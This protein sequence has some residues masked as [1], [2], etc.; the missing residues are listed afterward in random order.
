MM[1]K[2]SFVILLTALLLIVPLAASAQQSVAVP[3]VL[4]MQKSQAEQ[5]LRQ[6]GFNPVVQPKATM[7]PGQNGIVIQQFPQAGQ[8]GTRGMTVTLV[9][10]EVPA[11]TVRVPNVMGMTPDQAK[12]EIE[13]AGLRWREN[14]QKAPTADPNKAGKVASQNPADS[15]SIQKGGEV[16]ISV[17]QAQAP[18]QPQAQKQA[19]SLIGMT[20]DQARQVGQN[21]GFIV[22]SSIN[23]TVPNSDPAK[24][25]R[26]GKQEI[27]PQ[28]VILVSLYGNPP[29]G[30]LKNAAMPN[31]VGMTYDQARQT[32]ER[33]GFNWNNVQA[34]RKPVDD[35]KLSAGVIRAQDP[36]PGTTIPT[37]SRLTLWGDIYQERPK[38][39][40]PDVRNLPVEEAKKKI[41]AAGFYWGTR[42]KETPWP[43]Y[44]GKVAEQTPTPG[45]SLSKGESVSL[46]VFQYT[47]SA[48]EVR[49]I[50][51]EQAQTYLIGIKGGTLPYD[52]RLQYDVPKNMAGQKAVEIV[53]LADSPSSPGWK[54]YRLIPKITTKVTMYVTD[55][56]GRKHEYALNVL[57]KK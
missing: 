19:P 31:V 48:L 46:V 6:A 42:G 33:T 57:A 28:N 37:N 45:T 39:A 18:A 5:V 12:R 27:K 2:R 36:K 8:R 29:Q 49:L 23:E 51:M 15:V 47:E 22:V 14:P 53:G 10:F 3:H 50:R 9:A 52:V 4:G 30:Q 54:L 55:A 44:N 7:Y 24:A 13:K 38:I 20:V 26:V 43:Q 21:A 17:Y 25:N 40:V 16:Y 56:K 1:Q 11:S 35:Q 32:L 34:F 41:E